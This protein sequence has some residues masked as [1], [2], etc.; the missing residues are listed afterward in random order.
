[1]PLALREKRRVIKS[2]LKNAAYVSNHTINCERGW[3]HMF[4]H[5]S[6]ELKKAKIRPFVATLM[7]AT[8][9][10]NLA[11]GVSVSHV[12]FELQDCC[13]KPLHTYSPTVQLH[14]DPEQDGQI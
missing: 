14:R 11:S 1:M 13:L 8:N 3:I 9:G 10:T 4:G 5:F 7:A 6:F 12:L 2:L